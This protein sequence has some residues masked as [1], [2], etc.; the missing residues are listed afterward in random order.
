MSTM[1]VLGKSKNLT[2]K[3]AAAI[4][5][6]LFIVLLSPGFFNIGTGQAL[7]NDHRD[8]DHRGDNK[9]NKKVNV[10]A[11]T[12]AAALTACKQATLEDYNLALGNCYNVSDAKDKKE[13]FK[14]AKN[15][16]K[17]ANREC[18]DQRE[19]RQEVC[20]ELGKGPYDPDLDP[21]DFSSDITNKYFPL[22]QGQTYTYLSEDTEGN[23][24]TIVVTVQG[25]T[26]IDGFFC[27]Q[28]TDKVYE[29]KDTSGNL[30]EDTIDWFS[31]DSDGNVW[32]F[33][34][35]TIAYTYD[36]FGNPTP[37]TEG[38]WKAGEDGAKPGI[39]MP[40]DPGDQIGQLY[41][42]EFSLGN[43]EDLG[44]VVG[45]VYNVESGVAID[46]NVDLDNDG[47]VDGC[48]QTEDSTPL[49]PDLI[50]VKY[51]APGVGLVLTIEPEGREELININP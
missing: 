51:Y 38:S 31:Q 28:V 6:L 48:V 50:E 23:F 27:R 35:S 15:D 46:C 13:C 29:G 1:D 12:T 36:E 8:Y 24:Q 20:R 37:S 45:I 32:Y 25:T 18:T 21:A 5:A 41:R 10:C 34:E 11:Q 4:L 7:A 22:V 40:A 3:I 17:D 30:L 16:F 42:Q 14:E 49:E 33:G 26:T 9:E 39:I 19:A 43:A 2:V 47:V 44:R